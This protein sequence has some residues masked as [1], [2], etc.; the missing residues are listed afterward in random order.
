[1]TNEREEYKEAIGLITVTMGSHAEKF[2][3]LVAEVAGLIL[4]LGGV[5]AQLESMEAQ[6]MRV[7]KT[8]QEITTV[9]NA[10]G[11]R[12]NEIADISNTETDTLRGTTGLAEQLLQGTESKSAQDGLQH[13]QKALQAA[14][15]A[16]QGTETVGEGIGQALALTQFTIVDLVDSVGI[17]I[18]GAKEKIVE[19]ATASGVSTTNLNVASS[20]ATMAAADWERY[21]RTL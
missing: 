15:L 10:R 7:R 20:Q 16:R 18:L 9:L 12:L 21:G 14:E 6:L 5:T 4:Q 2:G 13:A 17:Q 1:M 19:A 11:D 8:A 3:S